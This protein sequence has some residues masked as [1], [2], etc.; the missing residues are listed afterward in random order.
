MANSAQ[1]EKRAR[2][3]EKRRT[4]GQML[5]TRFRTQVK[6]ARAALANGDAAAAKTAFAA[7]QESADKT[8]SKGIIHRNAAARIKSRLSRQLKTM[9]P[10][11]TKTPPTVAKESPKENPGE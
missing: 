10:S 3:A 4:R 1:S 11:E 7:M 6:R 9:K 2:Q 8:A 5:R